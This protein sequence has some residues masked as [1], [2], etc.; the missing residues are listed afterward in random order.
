VKGVQYKKTGNAQI[1]C[2]N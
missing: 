1:E 2:S